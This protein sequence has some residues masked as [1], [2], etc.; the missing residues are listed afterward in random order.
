[1]DDE[2]PSSNAFME[3]TKG[4]GQLLS[5]VVPVLP[6]LP[7]Y[8]PKSGDYQVQVHIIEAR[9]LKGRGLGDMSDPVVQV[10]VFGEV[11]S[12]SIKKSTLN[13]L[14]DEVLYF[15]QKAMEPVR[16]EMEKLQV[17]VL[18]A[19]TFRKNVVIGTY[20]FDLSSVYFKQ[21]HEV[22]KCWV[23]LSDTSSDSEGIQGYL[24]LSVTCLGPDDEQK[25]HDNQEDDDDESPVLMPPHV[26]QKGILVRCRFLTWNNIRITFES[27]GV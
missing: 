5:K 6:N 22:Y 4:V 21:D 11:K 9:Q 10:S 2:T 20:E 19:N 16:L 24:R 8:K 3:P 13:C 15:E 17:S 12:T 26:E 18:D 23:A 25:M 27:P 7:Q 1:M 14:W